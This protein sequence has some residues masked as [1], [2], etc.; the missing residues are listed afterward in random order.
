MATPLGSRRFLSI[1]AFPVYLF[2]V[3]GTLI[4]SAA[5]ICGAIQTVLSKTSRNDVGEPILKRYIGYHLLEL[6]GD[7]FP[8]M[9]GEEMDK[10][11]CDYR[12]A[13][14]ARNHR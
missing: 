10:L 9:S 7:L 13:Y 1:P 12:L 4:D 8:E 5:D 14:P 2:D 11:I 6:F 3:D